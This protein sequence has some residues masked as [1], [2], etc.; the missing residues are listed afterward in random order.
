MWHIAADLSKP[1]EG[2]FTRNELYLVA[3]IQTDVT[4]YYR[5]KFPA[6]WIIY[7]FSLINGQE[8]R[9]SKVCNINNIDSNIG[10]GLNFATWE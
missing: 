4:L 9:V 8:L 2:L 3:D 1:S 6:K 7:P 10:D 5:L